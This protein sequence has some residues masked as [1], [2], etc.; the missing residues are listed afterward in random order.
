[1]LKELIF[2]APLGKGIPP[3]RCGGAEA[4]CNKTLSIYQ[5]AGVR[6]IVLNKPAKAQGI[7]RYA[8]GIVVIPLRLAMLSLRHRHAPVHI[9]GFYWGIALYEYMLMLLC[10]GLGH[11]TIYEPRNGSLVTSYK[12]GNKFY[13][14]II[15]QLLVKPEVVLCQGQEYVDFICKNWGIERTYFPN[16]ISYDFFL[17]N[18]LDRRKPPIRLTYFGRV[19]A[20]KNIAL[21]IQTLIIL[22]KKGVDAVL[23]IIGGYERE[24]YDMLRHQ[25]LSGGVEDYVTFHE[26]QQFSYIAEIL[27]KSHYFIFPS[28]EAQEGHSNAL[29]EAMGC[30]VVPIVNNIGF[31]ASVC[32]SMDLVVDSLAPQDYANKIIEI[33]E[34]HKWEELSK[35]VY[36]RVQ[37]NYTESIVGERLISTIYQLYE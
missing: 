4:G 31:N 33:E 24:Y 28:Q 36:N 17:P 11:K 26:R 25:V 10:R 30:G 1:M 14:S 16:F 3:S 6:V 32:G 23:D 7:I 22:K 27:R 37:E 34:I 12:Q 21:I 13:R 35:F 18:N 19:T 29:T 2:Y 20:S 8:W 5:R 15:K 9:V